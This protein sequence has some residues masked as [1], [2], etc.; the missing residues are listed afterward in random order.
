M[1]N[2]FNLKGKF[3]IFF[4]CTIL[5]STL[6]PF[7]LINQISIIC[8]HFLIT[9]V[10]VAGIHLISQQKRLLFWGS[11]LGIFSIALTWS[12]FFFNNSIIA[13]LWSLCLF[14]FYI[15]ITFNVLRL[16]AMSKRMTLDT[17]L[18]AISGY[19]ILA[20]A[21]GM[22]FFGLEKIY[23]GSFRFPAGSLPTP[24]VFIYY[25]Q[26]TISSVG[27]GD[28]TPLTPIARSLSAFLGIAGQLYLAVLV[29]I[30]IGVYLIQSRSNGS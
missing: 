27:F 21:W 28:I 13:V 25:A 19:F 14:V 4:V 8:L 7:F 11:M 24:D 1:A 15:F 26:T 9:L 29:A 23:P 30:L 18:G 10:L 17:I 2:I 5:L 3:T 20:I 12:I 6:Y 22:L 16:V